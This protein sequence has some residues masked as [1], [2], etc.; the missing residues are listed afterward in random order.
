MGW[1]RTLRSLHRDV[2]YLC[3]GLTVAYAVTG[4][5]LNHL[6]D[7][8]PNYRVER[9]S[10]AIEPFPDPPSFREADVPALLSKIG[11]REKP[12]GVFTPAPGT[13]QIFFQGG[14]VIT[15][16]LAAGRVEGEIAR[17]RP[18]LADLNALHL[19]RA[20]RAWTLFSDVYAVALAFLC[21]SGVLILKDRNGLAGRGWWLMALG[22][23]LPVLFLLAGRRG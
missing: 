6:H 13:V 1:R 5:L 9:V 22:V 17:R 15:A 18:V 10:R 21:A 7:W 16:D 3:F 4:V 2:G 8:N 19:N 12:T 23:L 14:R 20:G 11:E